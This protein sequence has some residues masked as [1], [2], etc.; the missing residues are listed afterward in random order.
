MC[1]DLHDLATR[2]FDGG[3]LLRVVESE[4][5]RA[6]GDRAAVAYENLGDAPVRF[7]KDRDG[8]EEQRGA[9]CGR[10]VVEHGC[11]QSHGQNDAAR[12][13]PPKLEPDGVKSDFLAD[14]LSLAIA[15]VKIVGKDCQQRAEHKLKHGQAPSV[16]PVRVWLPPCRRLAW[17]LWTTR[18]G[19]FFGV[20]DVA[21]SPVEIVS[22]ARVYA[23]DFLRRSRNAIE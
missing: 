10:V 13:A 9:G 19:R 16:S 11:D 15:A 21:V 1:V 2:S 23:G 14:S 20:R 17:S 4:D 22:F 5:R 6:F 3:F 12:D 8:A 7:R 18:R